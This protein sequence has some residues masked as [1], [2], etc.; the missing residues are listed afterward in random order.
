[1]MGTHNSEPFTGISSEVP[2]DHN[3]QAECFSDLNFT[4]DSIRSTG[5]SNRLSQ[6]SLT[7]HRS[8]SWHRLSP[9]HSES[10]QI[11]SDNR[12]NSSR[13]CLIHNDNTDG[14]YNFDI[15]DVISPIPIISSN[16]RS[17]P[18]S[19]SCNY[20]VDNKRHGDA[21]ISHVSSGDVPVSSVSTTNSKK[22]KY[23]GILYTD[24][25]PQEA[26]EHLSS[27]DDSASVTSRPNSHID[28]TDAKS[29]KVEE[30]V[31]FPM[32]EECRV[33]KG[34][35]FEELNKFVA[36]QCLK[37]SDVSYTKSR[38]YS[39]GSV[40]K[41]AFASKNYLSLNLDKCEN[42]VF[43]EDYNDIPYRNS[44]SSSAIALDSQQKVEF[45]SKAEGIDISDRFS[46]FSSNTEKTIHVREIGDIL[47]EGETF[48]DIFGPD[49]GTW[50]LDCLNPTDIEM[51]MLQKVFSIH[52]LTAEDIR[53][54]ETREKV[55]LFRSYYFVCF[56]S[57]EQDAQ[58]QDYLEP[59]NIYIVV[60]REGLLT[61]H[62]SPIVHPANVRRRIR[63]LR[64]YV[65]I[66]SDW[67]CYALID[68]ITD[69]FGPCIHS[70][71][72]ET[73]AIE[74]AVLIT[75]NHES[76]EMLRAIG[77]CRRKVLSLFRLLY[78][79]ADVIKMFA[80]RC[81]ENYNVA[82]KSEIGLYLGDIQDHLITMTQ[83][84]IQF[85]KILSRSHSNY[86]AQLSISYVQSNERSS[87]MFSKITVIGTIFLPA[88]IITGLF[89]MNVAVPGEHK[90]GWFWGIFWC[91]IGYIVLVLL[92]ARHFK[93]I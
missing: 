7:L 67:I 62:F 11:F 53:V 19:E 42:N 63:Q 93:L 36:S 5:F 87:A 57:F 89:G 69:G 47:L 86:L 33:V 16:V 74:D 20:H 31:C 85:E 82:P 29:E 14:I 90:S 64:D 72:K 83:N 6:S 52:P 71:E 46:F 48:Q 2:L 4:E 76:R 84:L 73:D 68:D 25:Q 79:K 92:M 21:V 9:T 80:K 37:D 45:C 41:G 28:S 8:A 24:G 18:T 54:Q 88:N 75:R 3:D 44:L 38:K 34:V 1:M 56:R 65:D 55:E 43:D 40:V 78:G 30:D 58:S 39:T 50:W 51:K 12:D 77:C 32:T 59:V 70:I 35:D 23:S 60:F 26:Y 17:L 15:K 27:D 81:T 66:S 61:F 22:C 13:A 91:I 10:S 49:R